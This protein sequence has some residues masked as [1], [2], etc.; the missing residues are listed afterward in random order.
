MK[1]L[2]LILSITFLMLISCK[3]EQKK[4]TKTT[5]ILKEKHYI[6]SN[7]CENSGGDVAGN[8]PVCNTPYTHNAAY[9]KDDL[10]KS[11]PLKVESN[12]TQ[13]NV[14][15]PKTTNQPSPAKNASG[16][17]HYTCKNGCPGGAGSTANCTTCG[18]TLI[19]NPAY[20]N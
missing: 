15:N 18:E 20:H 2:K 7:K 14:V 3:N 11:G 9:H 4:S 13:P 8:C 5:E 10:L 6:C 17:Y 1:L 19:H 12:A 16:V